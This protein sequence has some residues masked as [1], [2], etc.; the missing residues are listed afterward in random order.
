MQG[1]GDFR[2][3]RPWSE[4]RAADY[5][6]LLIPGGRAP[7]YLRLYPRVLE[8]VREFDAAKK[9][10][11]DS[12]TR[13]AQP[14]VAIATLPQ[15]P[16]FDGCKTTLAYVEAGLAPGDE[17]YQAAYLLEQLGLHVAPTG[18]VVAEPAAGKAP[19]CARRSVAVPAGTKPRWWR[20]SWAATSP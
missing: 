13:F 15:E 9:P 19:R 20:R 6:A 12:G 18:V 10:I 16:D 14:G 7:E 17:H 5:D 3:P 8:L 11:A 2:N 4:L 1:S